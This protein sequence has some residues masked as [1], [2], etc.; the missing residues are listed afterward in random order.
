MAKATIESMYAAAV[1]YAANLLG[2]GHTV[3]AVIQFVLRKFGLL[4]ETLATGAV[5]VA[6]LGV[7]SGGTVL[8]STGAT[9]LPN[10][11]DIP[12]GPGTPQG[13]IDAKITSVFNNPETGEQ[14]YRSTQL[15]FPFDNYPDDLT[16][17]VLIDEPPEQIKESKQFN[18]EWEYVDSHVDYLFRGE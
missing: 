16:D 11:S 2:I 15:R 6:Q 13:Q 18:P 4:G 12:I 10:I 8:G 7:Q 3:E 17:P 14:E 1:Y 9:S 5:A